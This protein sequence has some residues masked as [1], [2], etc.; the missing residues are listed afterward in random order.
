MLMPSPKNGY[1]TSAQIVAINLESAMKL[2][3]EEE[4]L[5]IGDIGA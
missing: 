3:E 4:V 1:V 5:W 2:P